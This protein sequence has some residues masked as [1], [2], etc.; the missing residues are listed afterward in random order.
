MLSHRSRGFTLIELL[1]VIAIIAILAGMLFPVFSR[2]REKARQTSCMSNL[3]QIGVAI[4]M[5]A[6]D[7]DTCLPLAYEYL[8][9][10]SQIPGYSG[11]FGEPII[12]DV[13]QPYT[14]NTQIF[15]CPSD[16]D[17]YWKEQKMSY[18]Y[19]NG[20]QEPG[21]WPEVIDWPW[22][23]EPTRVMLIFDYSPDWH[24]KGPNVCYADG[25]VK[26]IAKQ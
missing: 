1:V 25:H 20:L 3:R 17:G 18:D 6:D 11:T 13:L 5:Y 7:Y 21:D 10:P 16:K 24:A 14:K 26:T 12:S 15:R 4:M 19:A 23:T 8:V 22:N 9:A 2:A